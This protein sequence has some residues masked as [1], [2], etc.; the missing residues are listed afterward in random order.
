[1]AMLTLPHLKI[2]TVFS[3]FPLIIG[4]DSQNRSTPAV[5]LDHS[6]ADGEQYIKRIIH[7]ESK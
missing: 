6:V 4:G 3:S 7:G 2:F 1:M 5:D